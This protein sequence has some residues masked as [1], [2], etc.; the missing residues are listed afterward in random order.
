ML[1]LFQ[2]FVAVRQKHFPI[3]PRHD[4]FARKNEVDEGAVDEL[5]EYRSA[6]EGVPYSVVGETL[7]AEEAID[8]GGEFEELELSRGIGPQVFFGVAQEHRARGAKR[9]QAVL[10]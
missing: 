2:V 1:V 10:I 3:G 7:G 4:V 6:T 8:G 9:N 5:I